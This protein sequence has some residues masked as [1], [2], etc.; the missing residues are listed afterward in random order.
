MNK[1]ELLTIEESREN[2]SRKFAKKNVKCEKI[3]HYFEE[4]PKTHIMKTRHSELCDVTFAHKVR[5]Q[6]SPIIYMQ[7]FLN[8]EKMVDR[9]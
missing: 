9:L 3:K 2:N 1:H 7:K 6:N 4:N 5:L 8:E